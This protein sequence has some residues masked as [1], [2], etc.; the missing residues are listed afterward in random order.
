MRR[1]ANRRVGI[2]DSDGPPAADAFEDMRREW[3]WRMGGK[4]IQ[5]ERQL[6]ALFRS[7]TMPRVHNVHQFA[8]EGESVCE[9]YSLHW[10]PL[11]RLS[12]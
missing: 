7:G 12:P 9:S 2:L 4:V 3:V 6:N 10:Q 5:L 1:T 8:H 11:L